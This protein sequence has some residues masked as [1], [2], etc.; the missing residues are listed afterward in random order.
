MRCRS[1]KLMIPF[2]DNE[3]SNVTQSWIPTIWARV[4]AVVNDPFLWAGERAGLR[5][6]RKELLSRARG[7]TVEIGSGTG[8]NLP[9]YP[10]DIDELVLAEPDAPMRSRLEKKLRQRPAGTATRHASRAAALRRRLGGHS[11]VDLRVVH[12]RCSR[13]R[14][15]GSRT[16]VTARR[17]V[18]LHRARPL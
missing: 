16:G 8:L 14:P 17:T 11:R 6:Q 3:L 4:F 7:C 12:G 1:C 9:Y 15:A 13:P 10:D 18:A 2:M 5:A